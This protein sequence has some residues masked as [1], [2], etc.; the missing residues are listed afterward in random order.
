MKLLCIDGKSRLGDVPGFPLPEEHVVY[1]AIQTVEGWD[2]KT[3]EIRKPCY[4]IEE[5][6]MQTTFGGK[7]ATLVFETDRFVPLSNK[8]ER[9]YAEEVLEKIFEPVK[10][11]Q[12]G[13]D[14]KVCKGFQ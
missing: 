14:Y 8:D 12:H 7:P 9:E 1:T 13:K 10:I 2:L 4:L 5:L 11:E 6:L 3:P